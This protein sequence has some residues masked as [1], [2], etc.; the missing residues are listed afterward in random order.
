MK[1]IFK[2]IKH[3]LPAS[4]VVF[5]VALPLC[6][7][8]A[9]ASGAP[10][11]AGIIAGILGGAY[12]LYHSYRNSYHMK[13]IITSENGQQIRHLVLAEE[14]SFFNKA[15]VVKALESIPPHS[16]VIID[17]SKSVSINYDVVELI[18][19][20]ESNAKTKNITVEK[21]SFKNPF[22]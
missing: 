5:F 4:I 8:I 15:S 22:I 20:Y 12:A 21:I 17:C 10:L 7:G 2:D 3:D 6:L 18:M 13:D 16:K 9:L 11:F 19:D 1:E 14:V